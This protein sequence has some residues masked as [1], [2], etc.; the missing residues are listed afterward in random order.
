MCLLSLRYKSAGLTRW[1]CPSVCL[2]VCPFVYLSHATC[3]TAG[4]GGL[5]YRLFGPHWLI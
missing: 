3:T 2:F 4:G 5:S 1:R